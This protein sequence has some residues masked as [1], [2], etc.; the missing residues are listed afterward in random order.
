MD[1]VCVTADAF[2]QVMRGK[3]GL[4][5][6]FTSCRIVLAIVDE[7]HQTDATSIAVVACNVAEH[8]VWEQ[9]QKVAATATRLYILGAFSARPGYLKV[10]VIELVPPL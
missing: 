4:S 1:A 6:L 2:N 3:S 8:I 7:A 5:E 9:A 10:L